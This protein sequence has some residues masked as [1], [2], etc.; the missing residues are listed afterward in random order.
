MGF[1]KCG[2]DVSTRRTAW[3]KVKGQ[4]NAWEVMQCGW[5]T[6]LMGGRWALGSRGHV[7]K[8]DWGYLMEGL[9]CWIERFVLIVPIP[10]RY[11]EAAPRK[12]LIL[13]KVS[14]NLTHFICIVFLCVPKDLNLPGFFISG[15]FGGGVLC[16]S[17]KTMH[18]S[19][20]LSLYI[21]SLPRNNHLVNCQ[22]IQ[23]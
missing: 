23:L 10:R 4:E 15:I 20:V 5:N 2:G 1:E 8:T 22:I 18:P 9:E 11:L 14:D 12:F 13:Q 3:P 6:Q 21:S 17:E 7:G 16:S 19:A